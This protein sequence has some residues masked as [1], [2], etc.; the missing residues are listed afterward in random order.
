MIMA[1]PM[2]KVWHR[3][4]PKVD[5][6]GILPSAGPAC[7]PTGTTSFSYGVPGW[8]VSAKAEWPGDPF[9][10]G[11]LVNKINNLLCRAAVY[12]TVR[13]SEPRLNHL[14][15]RLS[16]T[17]AQAIAASLSEFDLRRALGKVA[18]CVGR[19]R[20]PLRPITEC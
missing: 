20:L 10:L 18:W 17:R 16:A 4:E 13:M 9:L 8:L 6:W 11:H 3:R 7:V 1:A 5:K 14:K 15:E 19:C 12:E 2:R